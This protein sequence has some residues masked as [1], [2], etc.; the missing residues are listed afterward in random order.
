LTNEP[1]EKGDRN[2]P[3]QR[4]GNVLHRKEKKI[5][6]GGKNQVRGKNSPAIRS[7]SHREKRSVSRTARERKVIRIGR[8]P[9]K[10]LLPKKKRRVIGRKGRALFRREESLMEEG[11]AASSTS[12]KE[13]VDHE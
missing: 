1:G 12:K 7:P 2:Y 3:R 4:G 10:A 11:L 9:L 6:A 13:V 8:L 5:S